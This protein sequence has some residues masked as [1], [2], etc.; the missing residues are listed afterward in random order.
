MDGMHHVVLPCRLPC[1]EMPGGFGGRHR[2]CVT[3]V[4]EER[5]QVRWSRRTAGAGLLEKAG[6]IEAA[7]E[8]IRVEQAQRS[9]AEAGD[10]DGEQISSLAEAGDQ[11]G[12]QARRDV[13][14]AVGI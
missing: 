6:D 1:S 9:L 7:D 4:S 5:R 8:A 12:E 13:E 10:Q 3:T 14:R 11:D 2:K